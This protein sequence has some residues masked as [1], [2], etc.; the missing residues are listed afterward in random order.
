MF[1]VL[2]VNPPSR[3]SR[4]PRRAR[5]E[6]SAHLRSCRWTTATTDV[7]MVWPRLFRAVTVNGD[8]LTCSGSPGRSGCEVGVVVDQVLWWSMRRIAA[9]PPPDPHVHGL[10]EQP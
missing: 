7:P 10:A 8:R 9:P 3:G 5:E 2:V 1:P 6:T 4:L